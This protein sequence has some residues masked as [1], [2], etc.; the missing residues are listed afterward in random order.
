MST[1]GSRLATEDNFKQPKRDGEHQEAGGN[2]A[3]N[4]SEH[5]FLEIEIKNTG[6][7]GAGPGS[8]AGNRD[9]DKQK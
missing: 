1:R 7:K 3:R 2:D 5:G 4:D 8:G 6:G 9:G